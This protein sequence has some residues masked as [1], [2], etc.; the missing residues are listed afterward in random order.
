MSLVEGWRPSPAALRLHLHRC[1]MQTTKRGDD[2]QNRHRQA[3]PKATTRLTGRNV[4]ELE[5]KQ[6]NPVDAPSFASVPAPWWRML[7]LELTGVS[8]VLGAMHVA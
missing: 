3:R 8:R 5:G 7:L 4:T 2:H 1:Q 6:T